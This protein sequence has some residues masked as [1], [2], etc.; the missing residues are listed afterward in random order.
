MNLS[1][2]FSLEEMLVTSSGVANVPT[3]K[4]IENMRLLAV[5]VLQ[6]LRLYE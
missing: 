6:P 1:K 4:E 3:D 5:N 2:N